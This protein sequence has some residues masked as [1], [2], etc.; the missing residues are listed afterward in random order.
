VNFPKA[1]PVTTLEGAWEV[2]FDAKWG[3]PEEITFPKLQDWSQRKEEGI[4]HYSGIATYR[5]V[6][7]SQ[8][9]SGARI[10]LDLG[11]LHEMAEVALNGKKLGVVWC[12]PWCI[13][14]TGTLKAKDNQLAIRVAN[15]WTNRLLGDATKPPEKRLTRTALRYRARGELRPSGLLGPVRIM[16]HPE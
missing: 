9:V 4:R 1:E 6:F 13:D 3:G 10:C 16:A 11:R 5:K 8:G 7:D 14:I 12:A 15:L 2:S